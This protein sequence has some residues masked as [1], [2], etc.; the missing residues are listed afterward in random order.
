MKIGVKEEEC[1][2]DRMSIRSELS[3]QFGSLF[4]TEKLQNEFSFSL[5]DV[6]RGKGQVLASGNRPSL[7]SIFMH[8]IYRHHTERVQNRLIISLAHP[9]LWD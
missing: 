1:G 8:A 7:G 6:E 4:I 5:M 2:G 9:L 3:L